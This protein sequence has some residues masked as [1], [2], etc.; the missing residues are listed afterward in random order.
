MRWIAPI[1][2]GA[3]AVEAAGRH[4]H[5]SSS[6]HGNHSWALGR[7]ILPVP[8]QPSELGAPGMFHSQVLQDQVVLALHSRKRGGFFIDLAANEP[9]MLSNTRT[10]ERD[11]GWTGICI[12]AQE[13]LWRKLAAVRSCQVVGAVIAE[14]DGVVQFGN[15]GQNDKRGIIGLEY[16][17]MHVSCGR[18]SWHEVTEA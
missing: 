10:L 14:E 15:R 9:T 3:A 6:S 13:E 17:V 1:L 4:Q 5:N 8:E 2:L 7:V 18:A 11:F 16:Q 12:E